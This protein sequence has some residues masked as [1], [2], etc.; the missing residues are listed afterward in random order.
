MGI[1]VGSAVAPI[2]FSI[3]WAK[4]S[5]AGAI[6]GALSGLGG[7]VITWCAVAK[8]L[9]GEVTIDTL[10]Q[11]LPML[12]GNLVAIFL[13]AI[14]C[15]TVSCI[16]PQ[17]YDWALMKDIPTVEADPNA[18]LHSGAVSG[19]LCCRHSHVMFRKHGKPTAPPL[20]GLCPPAVPCIHGPSV[21]CMIAVL[22]LPKKTSSLPLMDFPCA[23]R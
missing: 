2:A 10:G 11:D 8:G 9:T 20:R 7:A 17:N 21:V 23:T 4:C 22:P 13:S 5:A 16:R 19:W 12:A 1:V 14:V 6:A 15:I 3:T 18:H